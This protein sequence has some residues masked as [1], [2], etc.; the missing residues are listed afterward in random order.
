MDLQNKMS[1]KQYYNNTQPGETSIESRSGTKIVMDNKGNVLFTTS[2]RTEYLDQLRKDNYQGNINLNPDEE[3]SYFFIGTDQIDINQVGNINQDSINIKNENI[4]YPNLE[5]STSFNLSPDLEDNVSSNLNPVS[6][7]QK[8][9][10][11]PN[12]EYS[13]LNSSW[14]NSVG[15]IDGKGTGFEGTL[16]DEEI[17]K[18]NNFF[19]SVDKIDIYKISK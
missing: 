10:I 8:K 19:L 3:E 15:D 13:Y 18:D 2:R 16:S 14:F 4:I 9:D 6:L 12:D 5:G 11:L 7:P 1:T 17:I